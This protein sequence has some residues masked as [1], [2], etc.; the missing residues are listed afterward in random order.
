MRDAA[1]IEEEPR[2][3][4]GLI[5]TEAIQRVQELY[6]DM[7]TCRHLQHC[8]DD[9]HQRYSTRL[10]VPEIGGNSRALRLQR[11]LLYSE[12]DS[13]LDV[14]DSRVRVDW[15][16]FCRLTPLTTPYAHIRHSGWPTQ[17]TEARVVA[18]GGI[19]HIVKPTHNGRRSYWHGTT[20]SKI[21]DAAGPWVEE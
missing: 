9:V 5:C 11:H 19:V 1:I 18:I 16:P 17:Y 6:G 20:C 3:C 2:L 8:T 13:R 10:F 21:V 15:N 4:F 7:A 14:L 12:W